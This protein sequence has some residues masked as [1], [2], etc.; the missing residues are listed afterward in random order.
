MIIHPADSNLNGGPRTIV[1]INRELFNLQVA[2][3]TAVQ[4]GAE[5]KTRLGGQL[6]QEQFTKWELEHQSKT[7]KDYQMKLNAIQMELSVLNSHMPILSEALFRLI[8]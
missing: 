2:Y 4:E 7:T 5:A 3:M 6:A 1:D 8:V